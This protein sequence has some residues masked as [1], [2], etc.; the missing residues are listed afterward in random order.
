M[1]KCV[2]IE[3]SLSVLRIFTVNCFLL[4][5]ILLSSTISEGF[6]PMKAVPHQKILPIV[7]SV[8]GKSFSVF[9]PVFQIKNLHASLYG[10]NGKQLKS[11][12]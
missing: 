12:G 11:I 3:A 5:L 8:D 1:L 2:S 10:F 9:G 6:W 4:F 7:V